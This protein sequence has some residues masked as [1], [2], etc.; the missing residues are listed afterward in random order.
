MPPSP[1][2]TTLPLAATPMTMNESA[3]APDERGNATNDAA[4]SDAAPS[5]A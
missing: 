2:S 1:I 4:P 5:E 3:P